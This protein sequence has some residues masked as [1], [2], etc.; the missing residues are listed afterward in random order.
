MVEGLYGRLEVEIAGFELDNQT[1]QCVGTPDDEKRGD[2]TRDDPQK[3]WCRAQIRAGNDRSVPEPHQ[4]TRNREYQ[5]DGNA[6]EELH[7][8]LLA[9]CK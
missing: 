2:D 1:D 6:L 9:C 3:D 8:I 4:V 7:Y 5:D